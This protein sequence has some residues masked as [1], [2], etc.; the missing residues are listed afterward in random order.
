MASRTYA[1][2]RSVA[3]RVI[4]LALVTGW[5][6]L[7]FAQPTAADRETARS[8]MQEGRDLRDKGHGSDA[9]KRFKAADDIMH[10]PTT[11]LEVAKT[12]AGL[13]MFVEARDTIANIRKVPVT[14]SDPAPFQEARA[15]ADEL[16]NNLENR[17]PALTITVTG[18]GDGETPTI[19]VDGIP[20]PSAA[21][22]LP[23]RVNPG[24]HTIVAKTASGRGDQTV[25]V[26]EGDRKDVQI[27]LKGGNTSGPE[28]GPEPIGEPTPSPTPGQP[29]EP[30]G[31]K[32]HGPT[33][34]TWIGA[35]VGG[36]GLIAGSI[37]GLMS[38]SLTSQLSH[39][40]DKNMMCVAG[41]KGGD[42][43]SQANSLATIANVSWAV[44]GVGAAVA[45]A[46]LIIGHPDESKAAKSPEGAPPAGGGDTPADPSAAPAPESSR[47]RV[48]PWIG[49]GSAGVV[50]VF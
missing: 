23:R 48:V 44:A 36:A 9:L 6:G 24:R 13:G 42:E 21:L 15:K 41:T 1:R 11:G 4:A 27:M 32:S 18:A 34:I 46:S 39:D 17:I 38:M 19:V 47:L 33:L 5:A 12:Q 43:Y 30:E 20:V 22:G 45:V 40:C 29:S 3:A 2:R 31:P 14:P 25:D 35:G 10:V 7:S 16:D 37:T 26:K 49:V 50:G 8:L 28:P